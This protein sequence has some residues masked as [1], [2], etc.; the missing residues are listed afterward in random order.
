MKTKIAFLVGTLWL[1][2][3]SH[4]GDLPNPTLTPGAI[5]EAVTQNNIRQTICVK[6]YTKTV[7]PPQNYTNAL[8]KRQIVEY[9]YAIRG[10]REYEEDHLI[11]LNIGGNPTDQRNLWPQP[12]NAQFGAD[13]KAD[14]E[15]VLGRMVCNNEI[16]HKPNVLRER[17]PL[18][19]TRNVHAVTAGK[20]IENEANNQN[21]APQND[22][23]GHDLFKKHPTSSLTPGV[24]L[25]RRSA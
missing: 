18:R 7:R 23:S 10:L 22:T 4:A 2:A 15:N 20:D 13:Q 17:V 16:T 6:G 9:G 21:T 12:R 11:S 19:C 14:L 5:D 3:T 8:K 1:A 24:Y 25:W